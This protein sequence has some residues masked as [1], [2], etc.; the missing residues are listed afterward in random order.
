MSYK[1][2]SLVK[3][4]SYHHSILENQI[5]ISK[6]IKNTILLDQIKLNLK[7]NHYSLISQNYDSLVLLKNDLFFFQR[8]TCRPLNI[9]AIYIKIIFNVQNLNKILIIYSHNLE[10]K[11]FNF[12]C[13]KI[14]EIMKNSFKEKIQKKN[15][16]IFGK[17]KIYNKKVFMEEE[18][19]YHI[20]KNLQIY[21]NKI[22]ISKII[23][24][25]NYSI[26]KKLFHFLKEIKTG[27]IVSF[28][29][30]S[31]F[32]V[33][34]IDSIF[35]D[36]NLNKKENKWVS[37]SGQ[38]ILEELIC[39][40]IFDKLETVY[41][42]HLEYYKGFKAQSI[43]EISDGFLNNIIYLLKN[44]FLLFL[45]VRSFYGKI[46]VLEDIYFILN[47]EFCLIDGEE[48]GAKKDYILKQGILK[49]ENI[50]MLLVHFKIVYEFHEE[51]KAR[52]L[53]EEFLQCIDIILQ[54][55]VNQ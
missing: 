46:D 9:R 29:Y 37:S 23:F 33:H 3:Y 32:F 27:N 26:G 1:D 52:I 28:N 15:I 2:L 42:K 21:T 45:K 54:C 6:E 10:Q 5:Q 55:L 44:Q 14:E 17:N 11:E 4:Q 31:N 8:I 50:F 39:D 7:K 24:T 19:I 34:T 13:E 40:E 53:N 49:T 38:F 36:Y 12:V 48:D 25:I 47:F 16:T 30:I 51:I 35:K 43:P 20:N 22:Q 41:N 18:N